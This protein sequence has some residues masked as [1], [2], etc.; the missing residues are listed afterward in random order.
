M[1]GSECAVGEECSIEVVRLDRASQVAS[2]ALKPR[3]LGECDER[4]RASKRIRTQDKLF[5]LGTS[6]QVRDLPNEARTREGNVA[7]VTAV[8]QQANGQHRA[9]KVRVDNRQGV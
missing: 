7:Q 2:V 8:F 5:Q 1:V 6:R 3:P 4:Y 9:A